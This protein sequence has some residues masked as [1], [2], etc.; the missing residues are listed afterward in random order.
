[1][2]WT[3][4]RKELPEFSDVD[5]LVCHENLDLSPIRAFYDS[6]NEMF[7]PLD[8]NQGYPLL[9]THWCYIKPSKFHERF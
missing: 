9:I 6:D 1:M 7:F 3:S 8:G 2:S 4:I 5:C